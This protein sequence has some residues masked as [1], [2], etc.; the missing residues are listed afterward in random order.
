M[1]TFS[2]YHILLIIIILCLSVSAQKK[3]SYFQQKYEDAEVLVNNNLYDVART[4]YVEAYRDA[5]ATRQHKSVQNQ[6]KQKI[7]LMDCY[8][9]YGHLMGQ[10]Q[11]LEQSQ[12]FESAY[13][14]YTDALD[15]AAYEGLN[16]PNND[17]LR[18]RIQVIGETSDLYNNLCKIERLNQEGS[19]AQARDL[20]FQWVKQVGNF[21]EKWKK[22]EISEDFARKMD[23]VAHFLDKD[24]NTILSYRETFPDEFKLMDNFLYQLLNRKAHQSIDPIESDI[25]FVF[26]LDTNGVLEQSIAGGVDGDFN[27]AILKELRYDLHMRQPYRYGFPMPAREEVKY[28]ISSTP[29][30]I[31]VQ[32]TKT[33]I[34]IKDSEQKPKNFKEICGMLSKAPVGKY[35]FQIRRNDIEGQTHTSLRII[36]AKGGQAKKWLKTL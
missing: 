15:Y 34:K 33:E 20:Y 13:K 35:C 17:Q 36:R 19:Y 25:T 27:N 14:Y 11:Q 12:D 21:D 22:H 9:R 31:W 2:R 6:I 23:S 1:H 26:T 32:K 10:A 24:R 3:K 16:I 5:R 7:V 8:S 28:H 18:S 4:Y 30:D 29:T